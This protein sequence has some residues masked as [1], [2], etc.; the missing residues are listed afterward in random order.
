MKIVIL[1]KMG[2][3]TL[4]AK[5]RSL[6]AADPALYIRFY[7]AFNGP[8]FERLEYISP[9]VV[10]RGKPLRHL[11]TFASALISKEKNEVFVGYHFI[12]HGIMVS[13]IGRIKSRPVIIAQTGGH[14]EKLVSQKLIF[15][16]V[17]RWAI[18]NCRFLLV[19]GQ[20]SAEF[21]Y[22]LGISSEKLKIIHS[23]INTEYFKP[24]EDVS[25]PIFDFIYVGI[26]NERKRIEDILKV[27]ASLQEQTSRFAIVGTGPLEALLKISVEKLN[28][29]E[30][31]EF[32]GFQK[33][34]KPFLLNSKIFVMF[35]ST[36]GLPVALMEA[37]SV[38]LT[39]IAPNVNNVPSVINHLE[40]GYLVKTGDTNDLKYCM[41]RALL[42][43][44][45]DIGLRRN[46]REKILESYSDNNMT[47]KWKLTLDNV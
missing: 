32:F 18:A 8:K 7:R 42:N 30:R 1:G 27:F 38:G 33:D 41:E 29:T 13:I 19:P 26:L 25:N 11:W 12:P 2:N 36:E 34:V 40:T 46:A 45:S 16:F 9:P 44:D 31:V 6:L 20:Q 47:Q 10:M 17:A 5:V 28:L 35:S 15:R 14:I 39:C 3:G 21:W 22:S 23:S 24:N 37:M 4:Q 43:Y